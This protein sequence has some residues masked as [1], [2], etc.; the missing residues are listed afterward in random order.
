MNKLI[1][2]FCG[3]SASISAVLVTSTISSH[4][5]ATT[6]PY[7]EVMNLARV[8]TFDAQ[9]MMPQSNIAGN[10]L[11]RKSSSSESVARSSLA[12]ISVDL[13]SRTMKAATIKEYGATCTSCR[14][15]SPTVMILGYSFDRS[16]GGT[17][18]NM[19]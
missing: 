2:S 9:G 7:P 17:T 18:Q 1:V 13:V 10:H 4:D 16:I 5:M 3:C 19:Y 11:Q 12:P 8:P 6:I 14:N 15:L